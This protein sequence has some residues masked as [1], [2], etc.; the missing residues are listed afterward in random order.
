MTTEPIE[1]LPALDDV[2]EDADELVG[3]E[4]EAEHDLELHPEAPDTDDVPEAD[5]G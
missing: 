4:V 1:E 5:N 2:P 3:D